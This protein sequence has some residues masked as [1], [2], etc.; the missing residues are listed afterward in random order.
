MTSPPAL[1]D[2]PSIGVSGAPTV[3]IAIS[4]VYN[5]NF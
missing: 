5:M 2:V 1:V 3:E 4:N